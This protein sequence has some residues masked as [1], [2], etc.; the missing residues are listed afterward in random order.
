MDV[1]SVFPSWRACAAALALSS[2][3][4]APAGAQSFGDRINS[5]FGRG[6]SSPAPSGPTPEAAEIE[7]PGVDIR[8]GASTLSISTPGADSGPM[9][10]RYQVSIGET[11]SDG[12]VRAAG[13]LYSRSCAGASPIG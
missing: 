2:L 12:L 9:T 8:Q 3:L 6:S 4:A 5:W 1:V 13:T 7:C 10:T 11:A